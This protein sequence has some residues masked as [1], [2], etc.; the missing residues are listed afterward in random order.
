MTRHTGD[1]FK[2]G[3]PAKAMRAY[4]KLLVKACERDA[5][6]LQAL[7]EMG[8]REGAETVQQRLQ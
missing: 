1:K 7:A 8:L 2:S 3:D 6:L 4:H 5:K